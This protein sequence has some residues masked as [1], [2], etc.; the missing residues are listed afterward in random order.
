MPSRKGPH[1][2]GVVRAIIR[3]LVSL[4]IFAP[5]LVHLD[6]HNVSYLIADTQGTLAP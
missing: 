6:V 5:V 3:S 2:T 4:M 1:L